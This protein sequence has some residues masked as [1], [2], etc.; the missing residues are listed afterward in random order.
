[1]HFVY[2]PDLVEQVIFLVT[3]ASAERE[4]EWH[5]QVDRLFAI[6]DFET[7]NAAFG[8]AH[9]DHFTAWKLAEEFES[10]LRVLSG[11][12][13]LHRCAM[14]PA[15]RRRSQ[16]VDLLVKTESGHTERT[17]FIQVRPE[18]ILEPKPLVPWLRRELMQVAD[19]LDDKFG[20]E[21]DAIVGSSWERKLR[22]DR[23]LVLWQIN[24]EGRLLRAGHADG[25]EL[26]ALRAA[27][28]KALRHQGSEPALREFERVLHAEALTHAELL[29]WATEPQRLSSSQGLISNGG[30][31]PGGMCPLCGFPTYDWFDFVAHPETE[32]FSAIL[33]KY[34]L[35]C[36][37]HGACR[38]CV[39][40]Y[41]HRNGEIES[42]P[43]RAKGE[44]DGRVLQKESAFS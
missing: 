7:R 28:N 13:K 11:S 32:P 36:T 17:L 39:E 15:G 14:V 5:T 21:P 9:G 4:C 35:W 18:S 33:S 25:K 31:S 34:P 27:F 20:Y 23:Y 10:L 26:T 42:Q 24:V 43:I 8:K 30:P 12:C 6:Q 22:Q 41:L 40:T 29:A 16:K 38:Q 1:M 19:M 2:H 37:A 44:C 3:R